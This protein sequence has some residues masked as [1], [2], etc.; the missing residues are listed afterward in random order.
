MNTSLG[1]VD[2]GFADAS[3][4][5]EFK[6]KQS[7]VDLQ[8]AGIKLGEMIVTGGYRVLSKELSHGTLVT[9]KNDPLSQN[10]KLG[11]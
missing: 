11:K 6:F 7:I 10:D 8:S 1:N 3:Q 9:L 5:A 2:E 4:T